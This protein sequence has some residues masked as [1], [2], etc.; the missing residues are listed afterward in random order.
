[1]YSGLAMR[2]LRAACA[3]VCVLA[4]VS[5]AA[6]QVQQP[7]APDQAG[8]IGVEL[9]SLTREEVR[10]QGARGASGAAIAKI[11]ADSPAASAGLKRGDILL[12]IGGKPV[13]GAAQAMKTIAGNRL[14]TVIAVRVLRKG[15]IREGHVK[16]AGAPLP[17]TAP[18]M[19]SR[20]IQEP[21]REKPE[22]P[23]PEPAATQPE[24][25]EQLVLEASELLK[26]GKYEEAIVAAERAVPLAERS[27]NSKNIATVVGSV[28][29]FELFVRRAETALS[30]S[31][32]ALNLA[33]N[34]LFAET[35]RA[36]A[37]L[38]LGRVEE[39]RAI[40]LSHKGEPVGEQCR[41]EACV[42]L[43]FQELRSRGFGHPAMAIIEE[44]LAK[45]SDSP[46]AQAHRP[47]E[48]V[49]QM[50]HT[51][52][53]RSVAFSPGGRYAL[54]G[55]YD[56]ALKLWDLA[57]GSELRSFTGHA[58]QVRSVAFSPDG[59]YALSGSLDKTMKL[60]DVATGRELRNFIHPDGVYSVAFSPDGRSTL[61]GGFDK[62]LKLWDVATGKELRS[63]TGHT[64]QVE[65][66]VFSPDGRFALSGSYDKTLKLW[67]VATGKELRTFNGLAGYVE[68]VAFS[69][70]GRFALSGCW[71]GVQLW[72]LNSS[73][74]LRRFT[75]HTSYT[76]S[77]TFSPDGRFALSANWDHTL[78]LWD[79]ATGKELRS[80][81]GHAG[82]AL[83]VAFSPNG[84]FALSGGDKALKVWEV[85]T[86]KELR[87][88]TGHTS[89][90]T[91]VA[92]SPN[93]RLILSGSQD[94]TLRLW[95]AASGKELRSFSGHTGGT[96]HSVAFSPDSRLAISSG[97]WDSALELWD[98][99]TGE[100]LRRF[101]GHKDWV[102]AVAISPD[103][104][105]ALSGG[106]DQTVK[107]WDVA[108]GEQL[109]NLTGH[110]A[111][112]ESLAFSPDGRFALSGAWNH[113]LILWDVAAGK[114]LQSFGDTDQVRAVAF[115]PDGRLALSGSHKTLTLRE[116]DT[117]KELRNFTG[118]AHWVNSVAF[119]S[120][121]R[122]ALSG[123][124]DKTL[125]LWDVATGQELRTFSGHANEV[126]SVAF[127]PDGRFAL[128]GSN[129][130]T[131]RVWNIENGWELARMAAAPGGEWLGI[132][133][134]GFFA[135]SHRDTSILAIVRGF[136]TTSIG[137]V[138]QSLFNPDL[139]REALAGDHDGEVKRA[140]GAV[141]LDKVLD[142]GPPPSV[143]IT[144][145][146]QDARS[147]TDIVTVTARITDRGK[148]VGR[149]EWRVN[150]VT[151]GVIDAP[152]GTGPDYAVKQ[153][154]ALDPGKNGI[155]VIAYEKRNLVASIPARTAIDYDGG[156]D[157]AKPML[158]ILAIGI[159]DYRDTGWAE[160][161]SDQ[162]LAF[163]PLAASVPDAKAFSAEME[164]A[165]AGQ[166]A[167]VRVTRA[168]NAEATA[169]KLDE[170]VSRIA[171][172][173]S[174]R[175]TFVLY[176]AAHGYSLNGSYYMIPQDY[177]GGPNPAA[178]KT[179]AIGQDRLQDWIANRI[180]AKKAVILLDTCE[181][182]ALT[183]G[184]TKS[185]TEGAVSE[186]A[187]GRLHEATGRP[188]LT[189]ASG[190]KSAYEGYKGH[191]VF[192]YALMEALHQSDT[193]NNGKIE[194]TE[195]VAHVE[196]RVPELFAEL[197]ASGGVVKGVTAAPVRRGE[198]GDGGQTAHF[199]STGEDFALVARLP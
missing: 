57:T 3:A 194:L 102:H 132:T 44:D 94:N 4:A 93:G 110:T 169:A 125:K 108:T 166:Y 139:V 27:Q 36:H 61:S 128:S 35:N 18:A 195:L 163:P 130:G 21:A 23:A 134:E 187:I 42:A 182:G 119:S 171:R 193:N 69:P 66:A 173:I 129:D 104:R 99:A 64:N 97:G 186:A 65:S 77:V 161:G 6:T 28:A 178:L 177:Q 83:S 123:S 191:G 71:D 142:A 72:D 87:A 199:G 168:L 138:H 116:L 198:A 82:P 183:G 9:R 12:E 136:E 10:N 113:T 15:R 47:A 62:T 22:T 176:A 63:F 59:R 98:V 148:G 118:H 70:D 103:G 190:G 80:F 81:S 95:E 8:Y 54:S 172:E 76:M 112:V 101:T 1:M 58:D 109:R 37:L 56:N 68:S 100:R 52:S 49:P 55:S 5:P 107:L 33:P 91:S 19:A 32:R 181:S 196:R 50:G 67:E 154:L 122:F 92:V 41:W 149:I 117:G 60:W 51:N 174:P 86:G 48:V 89:F 13:H 164:K 75:G 114:E 147:S 131:M 29:Y 16:F 165:G 14:G 105:F 53:I 170:A 26:A 17:V 2:Q 46:R 188:V 45:A 34:L 25:A 150:G 159:N 30:L 20:Q 73:Q 43:D 39:A 127:S 11:E 124:A 145:H 175:D 79:V 85:A 141:N 153:E 38:F 143:A 151:A 184:Y 197:K 180:K 160:P 24:R 115:S 140:A 133:P 31:E 179:R 7:Q 88:L 167:G 152:Q 192:T 144:S 96:I 106:L 135:S 121:G 84:R 155:E 111:D 126:N 157:A 189:A 90:V 120:D 74:E 185:R 40:Y 78:T 162:V 158:H 146:G 156:A 137:Q